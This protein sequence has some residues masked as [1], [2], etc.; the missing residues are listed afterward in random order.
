[1]GKSNPVTV[2][3]WRRTLKGK[4]SELKSDCNRK[5]LKTDLTFEEYCDI[6]SNKCEYCG[7]DL[8]EAGHGLDKKNSE[9]GYTKDNIVPC[10]WECNRIKTNLLTYEEMKAA[11]KV[12][13]E[14]RIGS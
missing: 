1:M 10:C 13:I 5:K 7:S 9:L 14:I 2:R 6:V 8:A 12:V 4:Y 3:K 11:M